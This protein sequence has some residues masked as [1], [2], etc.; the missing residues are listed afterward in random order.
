LTVRS[1]A[2]PLARGAAN[3]LLLA[4]GV[5]AVTAALAQSRWIHSFSVPAE[6]EFDSNPNMS[7]NPSGSTTWLRLTPSL[8]ARY[9]V[10]AD[11]FGIEAELS[12]EKSSNTEVAQDRLD[13]RLRALWKRAYP[14][15]STEVAAVL[16][17]RALRDLGVREQVPVGTDG[18]RTLFGVSGKWL[19]DLDPLS[20][21]TTEINQE[22]ERFSGV[23]ATDF[24]RTTASV[25]YTRARNER[26]S[27]YAAL[28]GQAYRP[29]ASTDPLADPAAGQRATVAGAVAG[30]IHDFTPA[31]RLDVAA[32]PVHFL[33][34]ASRTG[35]QGGVKA[36]YTGERWFAGLEIA[37]APVVNA[38]V[39]GLVLA[40][41]ARLRLRYDLGPLTR[42]EMEAGHAR[43]KAARSRNS[44]AN[45]AWMRQ[46]S[47]S[48][49]VGVKASVQR[50]GGPEGTA[51]SN[52]I[53][54]VLQYT[55]PDL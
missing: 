5:T 9:V 11:E 36:E 43:D 10:G 26:Q 8:G 46:F 47:P 44:L 20:F 35:W 33:H 45:V 3:G 21:V 6:I 23:A 13:P 53:G 29:Q 25:R 2:A 27:W 22:W 12:A 18:S 16:D 14:L 19:R 50:Q 42:L 24:S 54:V 30:V 41:E 31:L 55:A 7:I 48:W 49:Q 1:R 51:R 52:R 38:A 4:A 28:N 17:R 32:G 37:R 34:P 40:D 15:G 39:G